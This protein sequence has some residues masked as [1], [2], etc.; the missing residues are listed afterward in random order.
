MKEEVELDEEDRRQSDSRVPSYTQPPTFA[1]P[2]EQGQPALQLNESA[3]LSPQDF[4]AQWK[5]LAV[6]SEIQ[7]HCSPSNPNIDHV[8]AIFSGYGIKAVAKGGSPTQM[9]FF[10]YAQQVCIS[11]YKLSPFFNRL[12]MVF[13]L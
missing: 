11:I 7:T 12:M 4:E 6:S 1:P 3:V 8:S 10:L 2:K 5:A 13:C 9:K